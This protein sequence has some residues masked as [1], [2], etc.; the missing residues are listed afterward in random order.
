MFV[1]FILSFMG[2]GAN[3]HIDMVNAVTLKLA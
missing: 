2:E 3:T 1:S